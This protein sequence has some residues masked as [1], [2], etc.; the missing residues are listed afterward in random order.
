MSVP[1]RD[2]ELVQ[3]VD[4][5]FADAARRAGSWL[6]CR[7]GCSQCCHG[8]FAINELDA[9]RL[10]EGMEVLRRQ[11]PSLAMEVE[12]RAAEWIAERGP[13]FPGDRETG[14]LGTS[15][16]DRTRFEVYANDAPC[17]ALD[18]ETGRCDV[19]EWRP[20]TCRIFGPPIRS[21]N[22][23]GMEG[24]A[25]CELCFGGASQEQVVA[26]EMHLPHQFEREVLEELSP[27]RGTEETVVAFALLGKNRR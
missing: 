4:A 6:V 12:R 23:N 22:T 15:D 21:T 2:R 26:C 11:N 13:A 5:A 16:A 17:P 8:A 19:Y 24:L 7:P 3:I 9:A 10:G 27:K 25:H 18:P 20:V 1:K 14:C